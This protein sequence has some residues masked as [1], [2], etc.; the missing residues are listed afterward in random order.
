MSITQEKI[1]TLQGKV[2]GF[3]W[4]ELCGGC[5][6]E[7]GPECPEGTDGCIAQTIA[8]AVAK[9]MLE[10]PNNEVPEVIENWIGKKVFVNLSSEYYRDWKGEYATVV[11]VAYKNYDP[12]C[13]IEITIRDNNN[14]VF[15]GW[16]VSELDLIPEPNTPTEGEVLSEDYSEIIKKVTDV[17]DCL[18][19]EIATSTIEI[20]ALNRIV[21]NYMTKNEVWCT[22]NSL[23][24]Y[25]AKGVTAQEALTQAFNKFLGKGSGSE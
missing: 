14:I 25:T 13:R 18:L 4:Q 2:F 21:F 8:E 3:V 11:G 17:E 20:R 22:I 16:P 10:K 24:K 19:D 23:N 1:N 15:D 5:D 9:L 6:C 12:N 7:N